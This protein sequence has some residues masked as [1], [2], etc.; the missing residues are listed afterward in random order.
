ME[1]EERAHQDAHFQEE[2][3]AMKDS[4]AHL[5]NFLEEALRN[6]SSEGPS[7]KPA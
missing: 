6:A 7:A 2:L 5:T 4:V 1:N 3:N